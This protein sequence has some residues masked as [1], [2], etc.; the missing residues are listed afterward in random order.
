MIPEERNQ[1]IIIVISDDIIEILLDI[2][3]FYYQIA[4]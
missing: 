1:E 3:P 2:F 4:F